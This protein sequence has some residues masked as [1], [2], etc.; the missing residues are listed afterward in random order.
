MRVY[1]ALGFLALACL[2]T[3]GH[4]AFKLT[5]IHATPAA[6]D[7][8]WILRVLGVHW[9]Y[10]AIAAYLGTFVLW[11][12]LLKHVPVGPAFA[13][14]HLDAVLVMLV[15]VTWF[16]ETFTRLQVAGAILVLSG[17]ALLACRGAKQQ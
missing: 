7:I 2:D 4:V 14:T 6:A 12:T 5:A 8:G 17:V 13:V 10:V 16:G 1:Y 11:T 3:V 15:S 9:V